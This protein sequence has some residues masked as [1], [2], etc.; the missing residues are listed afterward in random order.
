[1]SESL[2]QMSDIALSHAVPGDCNEGFLRNDALVHVIV[3]T[4]E[5]EQSTL[6]WG[7]WLANLMNR[8][9]RPGAAEGL[10]RGRH[11]PD[12]RAVGR[13]RVPAGHR[14]HGGPHAG[15]VQQ[16]LG[17]RGRRPGDR[18]PRRR[19]R[20]PAAA[21]AEVAT[22][23]VWVDGTEWTT[24]WRY[25][26]DNQQIVFDGAPSRGRGHHR[27]LLGGDRYLRVRPDQLPLHRQQSG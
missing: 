14:G 15:R 17:V 25:D 11:Q 27:Q 8:P 2:L 9:S 22:I 23:T 12:V 18:V 20:V 1:M 16:R 19:H 24:G 21:R 13:R 5:E 7:L 6:G 10:R 3:V 26:I 4:D